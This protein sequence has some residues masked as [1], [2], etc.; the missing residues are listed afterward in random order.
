M[1]EAPFYVGKRVW[2]QDDVFYEDRETLAQAWKRLFNEEYVFHNY[3]EMI[4]KGDTLYYLMPNGYVA[5]HS[6]EGT[7][8]YEV[9][10][11]S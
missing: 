8:I 7:A 9:G 10:N 1:S 3:T 4:D 11:E 5:C 2:V 6:C